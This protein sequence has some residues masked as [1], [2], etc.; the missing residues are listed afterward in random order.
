[1]SDQKLS[2]AASCELLV[3]LTFFIELNKLLTFYGIMKSLARYGQIRALAVV[4]GTRPSY[5]THDL[6]RVYS[7]GDN[8]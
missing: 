3:L 1:M 6:Q 4:T 5:L 2:R 7:A 8:I